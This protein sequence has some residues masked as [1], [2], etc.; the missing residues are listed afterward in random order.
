MT[1]DLIRCPTAAAASD[2]TAHTIIGCG[3]RIPDVRDDEGI[4]DCPVCG[5]SFDPNHEEKTP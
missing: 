1:V 2:G 5:I 4:V 3:N